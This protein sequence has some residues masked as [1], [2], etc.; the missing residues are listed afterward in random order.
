MKKTFTIASIAD[1]TPWRPFLL[2][3]FAE[4]KKKGQCEDPARTLREVE[5]RHANNGMAC[6]TWL[7]FDRKKLGDGETTEDGRPETGHLPTAAVSAVVVSDVVL[8]GEGRRWLDL[9]LGWIRKGEHAA[10]MHAAVEK[11]DEV[12][13]SMDCAGTQI[14]GRLGFERWAQ[15]FGFHPVAVVCQKPLVNVGRRIGHHGQ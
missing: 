14:K 11:I 13:R 15:Q 7:V 4:V 1:I 10:P 9:W 6:K 3:V 8:D 5:H 2:E 12:A